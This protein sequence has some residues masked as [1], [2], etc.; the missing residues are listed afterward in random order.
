VSLVAVIP[1]TNAAASGIGMFSV[2]GESIGRKLR[3]LAVRVVG[4]GGA[5]RLG[6]DA[7]TALGGG[8]R[9]SSSAAGGRVW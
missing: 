7:D 1:G 6:D 9:S 8:E 5:R 4:G 2:S 3:R